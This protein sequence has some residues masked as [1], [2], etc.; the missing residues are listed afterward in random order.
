MRPWEAWVLGVLAVVSL[1]VWVLW[2]GLE[3]ATHGGDDRPAVMQEP[4]R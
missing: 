2:W 1:G 4:G 3:V